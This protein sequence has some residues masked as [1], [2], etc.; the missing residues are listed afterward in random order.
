MLQE[1]ILNATAPG[2]WFLYT[3]CAFKYTP[4]YSI[5]ATS[6][7]KLSMLH[8]GAYLNAQCIYKKFQNMLLEHVGLRILLFNGKMFK[9]HFLLILK[10][11]N[12][13]FCTF[14]YLFG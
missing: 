9:I 7:S 14:S 11:N 13:N 8:G 10:V 12:G 6:Y 1:H 5:L 2:A 3:H 4:P